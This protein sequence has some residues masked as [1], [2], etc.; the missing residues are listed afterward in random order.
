[1]IA[2]RC[3]VLAGSGDVPAEQL[4]RDGRG[5]DTLGGKLEDK[6][7]NGS[8]L[9]VRLHSAIGAFAVAVGTDFALILAAL[10]LGVAELDPVLA[11]AVCRAAVNVVVGGQQVH[12]RIVGVGVSAAAIALHGALILHPALMLLVAPKASGIVLDQQ[13]Q[14]LEQ[15]A[16][17]GKCL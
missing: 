4:P 3:F 16:F 15:A 11:E 14:A 5:V 10:H 12:G 1:M 8:G 2:P 7:H 13:V 17:M 9:R 6:L